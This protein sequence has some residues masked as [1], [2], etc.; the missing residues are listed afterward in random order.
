MKKTILMILAIL[1]ILS[2]PFT[3]HAQI[4][5]DQYYARSTLEGNELE[6]YDYF[7][8]RLNK[9][10]M[11]W[12]QKF[13]IEYDRCIEIIQFVYSDA[14][15]QFNY[16]GYYSDAEIS[17]LQE[18]IDSETDN[19]L[20]S[21]TDNM[22]DFEKVDAVYT[23]IE[24]LIEYDEEADQLIKNGDINN[25][26]VSDSQ[27]IVGGLVNHKAVCAGIVASLQYALYQLDIPCFHVVSDTHSWAMIQIDG[28][29]FYADPTSDMAIYKNNG[30]TLFLRDDIYLEANTPNEYNPPLP[31]TSS[32]YM[33]GLPTPEPEPTLTPEP[34]IEQTP[35][36]V[37]ADVEPQEPPADENPGGP[38]WTGWLVIAVAVIVGMRA[39]Q[40][41]VSRRKKK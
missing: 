30:K 41:I 17:E 31:E 16:A 32:R 25:K 4:T 24:K 23:S 33:K 18:Q 14:P 7:Y 12:D 20:L 9:N 1:L 29:W 5:K 35:T 37:V 10:I 13:G 19:I 11:G 40:V 34:T 22:S 36:P 15:E 8:D 2:F 26:T 21:I 6:F 39:L 3:A 28:E 38:N 27:T